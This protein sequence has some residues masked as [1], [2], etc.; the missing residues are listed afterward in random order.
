MQRSG[1]TCG[2]PRLQLLPRERAWSSAISWESRQGSNPITCQYVARTLPSPGKCVW[3]APRHAGELCGSIFWSKSPKLRMSPQVTTRPKA[4]SMMLEAFTSRTQS[5]RYCWLY[6][7]TSTENLKNTDQSSC[8]GTSHD[9][10]CSMSTVRLVLQ[11]CKGKD[12]HTEIF[13]LL[14]IHIQAYSHSIQM[15]GS[16]FW[17]YSAAN[18]HPSSAADTNSDCRLFKTTILASTFFCIHLSV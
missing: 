11:G 8:K 18:K 1:R 17:S 13:L 5:N 15:K 4:H 10:K 16:H 12:E 9:P 6:N 7:R 14:A 3:K 2:T